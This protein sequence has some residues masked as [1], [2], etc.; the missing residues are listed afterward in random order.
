MPVGARTYIAARVGLYVAGVNWLAA[1]DRKAC[2]AFADW[3]FLDDRENRRRK[4]SD[5]CF[6]VKETIIT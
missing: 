1:H 6:E 2:H 3:D 4:L 5:Q